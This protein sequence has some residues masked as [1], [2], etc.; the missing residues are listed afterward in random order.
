MDGQSLVSWTLSEVNGRPL[1]LFAKEG[2]AAAE[3]LQ[4]VASRDVSVV[5]QPSDFILKL[6]KQMKSVRGYKDYVLS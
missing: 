3:R 6:R 1:S 2:E 5:V 4:T